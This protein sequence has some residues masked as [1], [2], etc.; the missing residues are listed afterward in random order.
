MG[1]QVRSGQHPQPR[2]DIIVNV[3]LWGTRVAIIEDGQ[4]VELLT[5][6]EPTVVGNIYKGVVED[7]VPGL[8][9]AFVNIGIERNVFLHVSDALP[10]DPVKTDPGSLP[11]IRDVVREGQELIVQVTKGP[12]ESKGARAC[13]RIALPLCRPNQRR[14]WNGW[15]LQEDYRRSGAA[16][17]AGTRRAAPAARVGFNCPY[18]CSGCGAPRN[19][20]RHT[21]PAQDLGYHRKEGT[22]R[23]SPRASVRG[24]IA[25]L[26][27][28][29]RRGRPASAASGN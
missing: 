10:Y 27:T 17:T 9:A 12:I 19:T 16:K 1:E 4:L 29:A 6:R 20:K 22:P 8:D 7:V 28:A 21:L 25:C 5:E 3:G 14:A 2:C 11:S 24:P 26:R 23:E 15:R 18:P 13:V